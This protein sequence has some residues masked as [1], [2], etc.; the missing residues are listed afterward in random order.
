MVTLQPESD[1]GK[2]LQQ[3]FERKIKDALTAL[4][5]EVEVAKQMSFC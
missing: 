3:R 5:L 2:K 4:M 1:K